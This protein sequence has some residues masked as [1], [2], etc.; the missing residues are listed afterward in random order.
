MNSNNIMNAG[1]SDVL[2]TGNGSVVLPGSAGGGLNPQQFAKGM[3]A[4]KLNDGSVF[5]MDDNGNIVG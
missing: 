3:Y 5:V 2:P 1:V 4:V